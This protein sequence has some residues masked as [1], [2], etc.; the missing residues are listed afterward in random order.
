MGCCRDFNIAIRIT[1]F[2]FQITTFNKYILKLLFFS[3]RFGRSLANN[4]FSDQTLTLNLGLFGTV[5]IAFLITGAETFFALMEAD[6]TFFATTG[7]FPV[8]YSLAR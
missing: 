7:A 3:F 2:Y 1:F 6:F 4:L 5:A 8:T